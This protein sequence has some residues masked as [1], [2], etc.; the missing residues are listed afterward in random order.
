[1]RAKIVGSQGFGVAKPYNTNVL[2]CSNGWA[3]M[4]NKKMDTTDLI[5]ALFALLFLAFCLTAIAMLAINKDKD[6]IADDAISALREMK[7]GEPKPPTELPSSDEEE[8]A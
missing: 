7:F 2:V 8:S 1:M 6:D 5:V 4:R 3:Q